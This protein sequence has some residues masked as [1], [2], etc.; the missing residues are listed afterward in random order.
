[1]P[2]FLAKSHLQLQDGDP[3]RPQN[4]HR[5]GSEKDVLQLVKVNRGSENNCDALIQK[6]SAFNIHIL[7]T[8]NSIIQPLVQTQCWKVAGLNSLF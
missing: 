6:Y 1:M 7:N 5:E 8:I 4:S 2:F 3:K